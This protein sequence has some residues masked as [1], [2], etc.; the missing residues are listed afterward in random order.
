MNEQ[1]LIS[2]SRAGWALLGLSAAFVAAAAF[3][4]R[5]APTDVP[6]LEVA[7]AEDVVD[8]VLHLAYPLVGALII[9]RNRANLFGWVFCLGRAVLRGEPLRGRLQHLRDVHTSRLAACTP[10][11]LARERPAS[12]PEFRPCRHDGAAALPHGAPADAAL[13]DR[14]RRRRCDDRARDDLDGDP[15]RPGRRGRSVS[16]SEPARHRRRRRRRGRA[17]VCRPRSCSSSQPS[18]RSRRRQSASA[19]RTARSAGS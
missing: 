14:R 15:A 1:G 7:T 8:A 3:L 18:D 10:V 12:R 6:G 5:D 9:A 17:R 19:A 11:A 4:V 2:S 13:V 16:G